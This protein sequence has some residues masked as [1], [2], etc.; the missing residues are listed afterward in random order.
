MA[1]ISRWPNIATEV[2][3]LFLYQVHSERL[4]EAEWT[5]RNEKLQKTLHLNRRNVSSSGCHVPLGRVS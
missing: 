1:G 3:I 2:E 5:R 4:R